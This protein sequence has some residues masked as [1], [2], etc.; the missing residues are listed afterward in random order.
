MDLSLLPRSEW[1][2][3]RPDQDPSLFLDMV[4][5]AIMVELIPYV[6]AMLPLVS[7]AAALYLLRLFCLTRP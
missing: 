7:L 5:L 3:E 1:A 2:D 6:D 4:L